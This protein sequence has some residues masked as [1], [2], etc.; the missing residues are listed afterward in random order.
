MKKRFTL[1]MMVMCFLMC[2][3]L[4]MM[5]ETVTVHYINDKG[6]ANVYAYV[7]K[8]GAPIVAPWHG[9]KCTTFETVSGK[10]VATWELDLGPVAVNG[11]SIIFNNGADAQTSSEGFPLINNQYYNFDGQTTDPSGGGSTGGGSGTGGGSTTEEWNTVNTNRLKNHVYTQGF[12]LAGN[13]FTFSDNKVTYD[14]AVFKFQQQKDK[15]VSINV[16]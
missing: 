16:G 6:W 11:A 1:M 14:D 15:D 9:T 10:N 12:Y 8:A 13:F 7:Y 3:P 5:A 2:I 4:K